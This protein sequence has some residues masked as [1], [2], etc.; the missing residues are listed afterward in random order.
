MSVY[1]GRAKIKEA[2]KKL[3]ASWGNTRSL[4]RDEVSRQFEER[5]LDP[6]LLKLQKAEEALAY[7]D[8]VLSQ[9][10]RDCK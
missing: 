8:N 2:S 3:R 4:W 7:M 9:L 1:S 10:R 5:Q 6:L